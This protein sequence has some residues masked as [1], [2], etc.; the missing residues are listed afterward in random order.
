[1]NHCPSIPDYL[2]FEV[3]FLNKFL[4]FFYKNQYFFTGSI[5]MLGYLCELENELPSLSLK[6]IVNYANQEIKNTE[7]HYETFIKNFKQL[8]SLKIIRSSIKDIDIGIQ[9]QNGSQY[10]HFIERVHSIGYSAFDPI[11]D[12]KRK[13]YVFK[14]TIFVS[15]PLHLLDGPQSLHPS[16]TIDLINASECQRRAYDEY[17]EYMNQDEEKEI[18]MILMI[19]HEK[20]YYPLLLKWFI[21]LLFLNIPYKHGLFLI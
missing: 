2:N 14:K 12:E 8:S 10:R 6:E 16:I 1:M 20:R 7:H 18:L 5:A 15:P 11:F 3:D 19:L 13:T 17:N 21:K 9:F 4:Q